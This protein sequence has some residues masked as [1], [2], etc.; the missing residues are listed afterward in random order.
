MLFILLRKPKNP[1]HFMC[2]DNQ[3]TDIRHTRNNFRVP[4]ITTF[5]ASSNPNP[6]LICNLIPCNGP[7][8]KFRHQR[9]LP[10]TMV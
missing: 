1:T 2:V 6:D 9:N 5:S 10:V 8:S 3:C 4:F 7:R